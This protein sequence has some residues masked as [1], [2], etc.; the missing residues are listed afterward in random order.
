M[1]QAGDGSWCAA[2]WCYWG[3]GCGHL[4]HGDSTW[5]TAP[6]LPVWDRGPSS[7]SAAGMSHTDPTGPW[8]CIFGPETSPRKGWQVN[9]SRGGCSATWTQ[10]AST[11]SAQDA[12]CTLGRAASAGHGP[13]MDEVCDDTEWRTGQGGVVHGAERRHFQ[14]HPGKKGPPACGMGTKS[15]STG[16]GEET[17]QAE[18]SAV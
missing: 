18:I 2:T 15:P 17:F 14:C 16:E 5:N 6:C 10:T 9:R 11:C 8:P 12:L 13:G 1:W 7:D 4:E 3:Q